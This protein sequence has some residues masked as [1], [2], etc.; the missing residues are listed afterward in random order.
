MKI[1]LPRDYYLILHPEMSR[2]YAATIGFFDG[3]HQGHRCLVEQL[4]QWAGRLGLGSM[5][6][7]FDHHP[8]QVLHADYVP[9]LLSTLDE[10]VE[11]LRLTGVDEVRVLHFTPDMAALDALHFMREVL[12]ARLNVGALLMGYDH[13][14]GHGGGTPDQYVAWGRQVGMPVAL[15][16]EWTG[17]KVSSS[18]IRRLLQEGDATEAA[19]LLGRPYSLAGVVTGGHRVGHRLGYPTANLSLPAGKLVP[20]CGAYAVR[21]ILPGGARHGGM[22]CIG[23]RPT[24]HNGNDV[25]VEVNVF[26]F[27]GDLYNKEMSVDLV[28]HLRPERAFPSL[29]ALR[30]QLARDEAQAR[31]IL[32]GV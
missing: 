3:V 31:N 28:A 25:S 29:E 13:R 5:V 6:V 16:T 7:T 9:A 20:A 19:R 32:G 15:A 10:K 17:G 4:C 21:C 22:L 1:W 30:E 12:A 26:D 18:V 11:L 8:R 14:F 24:L 2:K 23:R 27:H